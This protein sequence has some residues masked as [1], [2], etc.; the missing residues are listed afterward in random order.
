[1]PNDPVRKKR[2]FCLIEIVFHITTINL[3]GQAQDKHEK[4]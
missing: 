2:P 1:M 3:P 4:S